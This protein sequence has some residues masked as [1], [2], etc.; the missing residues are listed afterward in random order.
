MRHIKNAEIS[1]E[2][3]ETHKDVIAYN[4]KTY[5]WIYRDYKQEWWF[6]EILDI[7][8]KFLLGAVVI[9][10]DPGSDTQL[11]VAMFLSSLFLLF[12]RTTLSFSFL[13]LYLLIPPRLFVFFFFVPSLST[14]SVSV[15]GFLVR[16]SF[17]SFSTRW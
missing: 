6:W 5:G 15:F 12:H 11:Y 2:Y 9:F 17:G 16:N 14:G 3:A 1:R 10:V 7:I 8:K 13:L 4:Q